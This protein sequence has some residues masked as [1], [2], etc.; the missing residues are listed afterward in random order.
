MRVTRNIRILNSLVDGSAVVVGE[1]EDGSAIYVGAWGEFRGLAG[2]TSSN[3]AGLKLEYVGPRE[4][5]NAY[6]YRLKWYTG[7]DLYNRLAL[8][9][10][11][12]ILP[13]GS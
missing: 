4:N 3:N 7:F 5:E 10:I 2:F 12:D 13:L 11:K 9:R 8:A 6:Q 1:R